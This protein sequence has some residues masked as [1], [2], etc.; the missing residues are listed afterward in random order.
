MELILNYKNGQY[1]LELKD[2]TS[3]YKNNK[4]TNNQ[5]VINKVIN[6]IGNIVSVMYYPK[7]IKL[8]LG[9]GNHL[10]LNNYHKNSNL[11]LYCD[12]LSKIDEDTKIRYYANNCNID[13]IKKIMYTGATFLTLSFV[14]IAAKNEKNIETPAAV[15]YITETPT[16]T[17]TPIPTITPTVIPTVT[18][19]VTPTATP[20]PTPSATDRI[21]ESMSLNNSVVSSKLTQ[22]SYNKIN[23]Y[24]ETEGWNYIQK[25]S[26]DF[27]VDPYLLLALGYTETNLEHEKTIPGG[28]VYNG[29]GVGMYQHE[30]P[31]KY[32]RNINAYNYTTKELEIEKMNME[33]AC[34]LELN[35]KMA[36]MILQNRLHKYNNNICIAIQSYN[37]GEKGIQKVL[38]SYA[39]EQNC[40]I[41]DII[42][43]QN[44]LGWMKYVDHLHYNPQEY[45]PD[46]K[47][48]TYGNEEYVKDVLGYYIGTESI[49]LLP[50]GT[51]F[52][53][54]LLNMEINY[55]V[56]SR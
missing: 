6:N 5:E 18:P 1:H 56:K 22:Y 2:N 20:T 17:N 10:I 13:K 35:I 33:S 55:D 54:N 40:S 7:Y 31:D 51:E 43:N 47:Y 41:E 29:Y 48:K 9:D 25:Y 49:N 44:D 12:I 8:Y 27:G 42:N 28:S 50:D 21:L 23:N 52:V 38:E 34:N 37:Y 19:T 24:L 26:K 36:A 4:R 45:L 46:W 39:N 14:A 32:Q 53:S 15:E 3:D 30:T 16:P 11:D